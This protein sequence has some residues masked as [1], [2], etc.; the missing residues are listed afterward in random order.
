MKVNSE[1]AP[2]VIGDGLAHPEVDRRAGL[3]IR[4]FN[5]EYQLRGRPVVIVDAIDHWKART[6][7]TFDF[8]KSRYGSTTVLAYRYRGYKYKPQDATQMSFGDYLDGVSSGD[9]NSFPY[10]IRDNWGVLVSHPELAA[11]YKNPKYFYDW[12]SLLPSFMR[13][14]Y[15]LAFSLGR[16]AR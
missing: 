8:F 13:L 6:S 2:G 14:K 3:S 5:R 16:R 1:Y 15:P 9:W 12:F 11:D 10:Y 4:E 7:W